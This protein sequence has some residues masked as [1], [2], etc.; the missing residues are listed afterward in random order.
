MTFL[1]SWRLVFILGPVALL[2]AYLLVQRARRRAVMRFTSVAMLESVAP[3]RPG[4]QRHIPAGALL[5]ALVLLVVAF[6]QPARVVRTP[7]QRATVILALDVSGSMVAN[8]VSP[9]RLAAAEKAAKNFVSALPSGV[10]LGLVTFSNAASVVVAP[11]SDRSTVSAAIDSLQARGGTATADA[12]QLS[13]N[14]VAA[15]PKGAGG[16]TAPAAIVLMSDG[17]PTIGRNDLSPAEAVASATAAARDAGV[18]INTIAFGTPD[19]VVTVQGR[20]TPVPSDPGAMAQIA[21]ESGG[22]TFTAQTAGQLN[23]VYKEIGRVVGYDTHRREITAWFTGVALAVAIAAAIAAL[24]W[25][26]R[27][28]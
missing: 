22:R 5:A 18:H 3:R 28:L 2:A 20:T 14:A 15:L 23:S 25:N 24:V 9:T 19:G 27:L 21:S 8:D 10:Q 7:R 4:W 13:L 26:Q 16:K 17:T 12:I 1:S 11:T 6:A